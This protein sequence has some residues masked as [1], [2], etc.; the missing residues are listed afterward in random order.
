MTNSFPKLHW[1]AQKEISHMMSDD[2]ETAAFIQ[3]DEVS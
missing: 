3:G 2:M 1:S